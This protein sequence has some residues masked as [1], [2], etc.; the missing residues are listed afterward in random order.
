MVEPISKITEEDEVLTAMYVA[1]YAGCDMDD[2]QD[3]FSAWNF[4]K[5]LLF[6][7]L[8]HELRRTFT[9][10]VEDDPGAMNRRVCEIYKPQTVVMLN[11]CLSD[12]NPAGRGLCPTEEDW[13]VCC[14]S[15]TCNEFVTDLL[16]AM[17]RDK[18]VVDNAR[19]V[20]ERMFLVLSPR[21]ATAGYMNNFGNDLR[22]HR[23]DGK[24]YVIKP[25]SRFM[26]AVR[27][28]AE[29]YGCD[30]GERF[31]RF[32]DAIS[33]ATTGKNRVAKVT[34]YIHPM[35]FLTA[36]DNSCG[37]TSCYSL[38]NHGSSCEGC[39]EMMNS[40]AAMVVYTES[41][42]PFT[43]NGLYIPN[44]SWRCFTFFDRDCI[45]VGKSY[46]Y[47]LASLNDAVLE[48]AVGL[49]ANV[50][51][52]YEREN[53][54]F[55]DPSDNDVAENMEA[56]DDYGR[57]V[58]MPYTRHCYNDFI[59]D[60]EY[61]FVCARNTLDHTKHFAITGVPTCLA[62]GMEMDRTWKGSEG[63]VCEVCDDSRR[64]HSCGQIHREDDIVRVFS[65]DGIIAIGSDE[66]GE[67]CYRD[68]GNYVFMRK[69]QARKYKYNDTVQ[70]TEEGVEYWREKKRL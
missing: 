60:K 17:G 53:E 67:Y 50:G 31:T 3:V 6:D 11:E 46:P 16:M 59:M 66:I 10:N 55:C 26:R 21:N 7:M 57:D 33:A 40:R 52:K 9:V 25:G 39:V 58:I 22:F 41:D 29:F 20:A 38:A 8:G 1:Q 34:F 35:D 37:W 28:L 64:C 23:E 69:E 62:C 15:N 51:W 14:M 63:L 56:L 12:F 18:Y 4:N 24:E 13:R 27:K 54:L 36:S 44:K 43:Y 49:A 47:T 48:L 61:P 42:E 45:L 65:I 5:Q 2:F 30:C 70:A 68:D 32:R 19:R